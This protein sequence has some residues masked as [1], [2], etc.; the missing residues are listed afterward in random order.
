MQLPL[1]AIVAAARAPAEPAPWSMG[2]AMLVPVGD[3]Q[4]KDA[5]QQLLALLKDRGYDM[6]QDVQVIS[7]YRTAKPLSVDGLN[8]FLQDV[9]NPVD[10]KTR[11]HA[12]ELRLF[13]D[14]R[15]GTK[16]LQIKND[17]QRAIYNGAALAC[18]VDPRVLTW[19]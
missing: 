17:H 4:A 18:V 19:L 5:L 10:P 7:A 11:A 1:S 13:G 12:D 6:L 2:D 9:L 14:L 16:V 15:L 3:H 8:P